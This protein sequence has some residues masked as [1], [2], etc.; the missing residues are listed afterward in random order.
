MSA[1]TYLVNQTAHFTWKVTAD[2][3]EEAEF[4]ASQLDYADAWESYAEPVDMN[5]VKETEEEL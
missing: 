2:T 3:P 4:K 1:K 5:D